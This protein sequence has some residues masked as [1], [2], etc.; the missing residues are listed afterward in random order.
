MKLT[1]L[2]LLLKSA[3]HGSNKKLI[4]LAKPAASSGLLSDRKT[5][6]PVSTEWNY[7]AGNVTQAWG[8]AWGCISPSFPVHKNFS[9]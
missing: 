8:S 9:L 3:L 4:I 2:L 1:A 7:G 5:S 6:K